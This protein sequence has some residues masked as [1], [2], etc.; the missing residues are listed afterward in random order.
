[1]SE[2]APLQRRITVALTAAVASTTLAIG[3][4]AAS[5]MGWMSPA[6]TAVAP[7]PSAAVPSS[8]PE[9]APPPV[10][11][12]PI[13]PTAPAEAT[14]PAPAPAPPRVEPSEQ[15]VQMAMGE[16]REHR[17]DDGDDDREGEG[18]ERDGGDDD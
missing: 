9:V 11:L 18:R 4:T 15:E 6:P 14:A 10:I 1:M 13:A 16:R 3:V 5:F 2:P 7:E 12:V 8:V 17:H